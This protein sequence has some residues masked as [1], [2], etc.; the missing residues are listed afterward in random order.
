MK[1]TACGSLL[2]S[3]ITIT[4]IPVPVTTPSGRIAETIRGM[5]QAYADDGGTFYRSG[6]RVNALAGYFYGFGWLHFGYASG[7]LTSPDQDIT[8]CPFKDSCETLD[9]CYTEKLKEKTL[10]YQ[11]LLDTARAAVETA[12]EQGTVSHDFALRVLVIVDVYR[13]RGAWLVKNGTNEDA[14]ASFSYGHG[15]LDAAVRSGLFRITRD[16]AIFTV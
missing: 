16:R 3:Q 6:D 12:P 5:A 4:G 11:R 13:A 8:S 7:L 15:W 2:S 9:E 1:I 14:L 10:R